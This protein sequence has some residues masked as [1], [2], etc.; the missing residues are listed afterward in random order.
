MY[1]KCKFSGTLLLKTYIYVCNLFWLE[2]IFNFLPFNAKITLRDK[3][4]LE[5]MNQRVSKNNL[6]E[7]T[8]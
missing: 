8:I 5:N 3:N 6:A 7:I 2:C 4:D 1:L